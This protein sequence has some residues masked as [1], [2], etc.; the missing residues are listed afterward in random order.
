[1]DRLYVSFVD[2]MHIPMDLMVRVRGKL[3]AGI[4]KIGP[5][6]SRRTKEVTSSILGGIHPSSISDDASTGLG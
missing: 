2:S 5:W 6:G 1:M 3:N 4:D